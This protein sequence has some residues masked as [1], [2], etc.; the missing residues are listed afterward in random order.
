MSWKRICAANTLTNIN[1]DG[2]AV[3]VANYGT[4]YRVFPPVC[5]HMEE[6]LD[7]FDDD[8]FFNS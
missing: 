4:G 2:I 5:P 6:P 3:I 8:D 7:A 1:V